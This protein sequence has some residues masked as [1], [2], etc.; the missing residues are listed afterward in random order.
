MKTGFI[1]L[2]HMGSAMAKNVAAPVLGR[3]DMAAAAAAAAMSPDL[4]APPGNRSRLANYRVIID[5]GNMRP[6]RSGL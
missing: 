3:P 1:G 6:G 4:R 5:G 2:G